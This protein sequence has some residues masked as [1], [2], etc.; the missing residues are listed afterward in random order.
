MIFDPASLK[1]LSL[2]VSMTVLAVLFSLYL[3]DRSIKNAA[4]GWEQAVKSQ[5]ETISHLSLRVN[6]LE[7]DAKEERKRF[8]DIISKFEDHQMNNLDNKINEILKLVRNGK[9][10]ST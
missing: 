1:D 5:G 6:N 7:K 4:K 3:F 8:E 2:P 10:Q 9:Q